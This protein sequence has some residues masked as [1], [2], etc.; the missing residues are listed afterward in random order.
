MLSACKTKLSLAELLNKKTG[1]FKKHAP[2][3]K[4]DFAFLEAVK[5]CAQGR[6]RWITE[7]DPASISDTKIKNLRGSQNAMSRYL[8]PKHHSPPV[9]QHPD[10]RR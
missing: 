7:N 9:R 2:V 4:C 1:A 6:E 10:R 3:F 8:K 5:P